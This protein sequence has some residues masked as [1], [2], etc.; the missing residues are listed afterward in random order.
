MLGVL[1]VLLVNVDN[2]EESI[3]FRAFFYTLMGNTIRAGAITH[4]IHI[5]QNNF[6]ISRES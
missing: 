2:V 3:Y 1:C 6:Y 4:N 5:I